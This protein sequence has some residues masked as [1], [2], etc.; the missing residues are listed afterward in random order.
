MLG[1]LLSASF[2]VLNVPQTSLLM[3][4]YPQSRLCS[5]V[6]HWNSITIFDSSQIPFLACLSPHLHHTTTNSIL[7]SLIELPFHPPPQQ[8][9]PTPLLTKNTARPVFL[10]PITILA[11]PYTKQN[12]KDDTNI[13]SSTSP[14]S[15]TRI[16]T[17]NRRAQ[18]ILLGLTVAY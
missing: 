14:S 10:T 2:L 15:L 3:I 7:N 5:S 12:H 4:R 18:I 11:H 16:R 1:L 6:K 13:R 17:P 9:H 8:L